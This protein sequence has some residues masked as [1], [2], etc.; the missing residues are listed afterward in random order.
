MMPIVA[1][2]ESQTLMPVQRF[3]RRAPNRPDLWSTVLLWAALLILETATQLAFKAGSEKLDV[4]NVDF[5]WF[6]SALTTPEV[7]LAILGYLATF[8]VWM[9]I[10][11]RTDL[12]KAFPITTLCYVTVPVFAW[13]VFGETTTPTRAMGIAFIIAGVMLLGRET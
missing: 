6:I 11:Q 13:L 5:S 1:R 2:A 10:L 4:G 7:W 3:S 12:S 9:L 8:V